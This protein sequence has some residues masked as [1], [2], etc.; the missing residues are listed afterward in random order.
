MLEILLTWM[1]DVPLLCARG[2]KPASR[3]SCALPMKSQTRDP[4]ETT[5]P[6]AERI[7]V[8]LQ[9]LL[10]RLRPEDPQRDG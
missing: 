8:Q 3:I 4:M 7:L 9:R 2:A 10:R 6:P 5:D 1:R